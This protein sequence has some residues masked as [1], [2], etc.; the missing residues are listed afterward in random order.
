MKKEAVKKLLLIIAGA[1]IASSISTIIYFYFIPVCNW[2]LYGIILF[3]FNLI[4]MYFVIV[5][6][7]KS[8]S[9][10]KKNRPAS[11]FQV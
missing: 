1:I 8:A 7:N 5:I 2:V 10:S 4:N 9:K 3:L 11:G 6:I